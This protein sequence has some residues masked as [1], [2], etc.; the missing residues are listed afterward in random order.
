MAAPAAQ[1]TTSR[2]CGRCFLRRVYAAAK[3][4]LGT[5]LPRTGLSRPGESLICLYLALQA[6]L[7]FP[8]PSSFDIM[9]ALLWLGLCIDRVHGGCA[10]FKLPVP[11]LTPRPPMTSEQNA[12]L[13][14]MANSTQSLCLSASKGCVVRDT[15][16]YEHPITSESVDVVVLSRIQLPTIALQ[17]DQL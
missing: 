6:Y 8:S 1:R 16:F 10:D 2:F 9:L 4:S 17:Y 7:S 13:E 5:R 12:V 11:P 3:S 15:S 14:H